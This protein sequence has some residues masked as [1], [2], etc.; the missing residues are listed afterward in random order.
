MCLK[1]GYESFMYSEV[2][3]KNENKILSIIIVKKDVPK[4]NT[5]IDCIIVASSKYHKNL[6]NA[7]I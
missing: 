1:N 4:I 5:I 7:P 3:M 2:L 6:K